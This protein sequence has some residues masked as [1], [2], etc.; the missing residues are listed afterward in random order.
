MDA[1]VLPLAFGLRV[2]AQDAIRA[3][4]LVAFH[5]VERDLGDD[6]SVFYGFLLEDGVVVVAEL[7]GKVV[8]WSGSFSCAHGLRIAVG[9]VFKL[10]EFL[11]P[12]QQTAKLLGGN[13]V[14][15]IDLHRKI[16]RRAAV[17]GDEFKK[18]DDGIVK[19]RAH[20]FG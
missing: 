2:N 4:E 11:K 6:A 18:L 12:I 20:L 14:V 8:A 7:L 9:G 1:T 19:F 17:I 5:I 13:F 15:E 16:V 10:G 3:D